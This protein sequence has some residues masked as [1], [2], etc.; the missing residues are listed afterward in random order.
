MRPNLLIEGAN[1]GE[2]L[3]STDTRNVEPVFNFDIR[4]FLYLVRR[5]AGLIATIIGVAL[6]LGTVV[7]MLTTPRFV[8]SAQLQID[9]E[10]DR[11]LENQNAVQP[12]VA[13][14]D[15]DRFLRTQV[16]VIN[17][18]TMSL[19][20]ARALGLIGSKA[21]FDAMGENLPKAEGPI[22]PAR[23]LEE[24][25]LELIRKH[26]TIDLPRESRVVKI[27]FE[28][29]DPELA[30]R[31]ANTYSREYIA[32]NLQRKYD[33]SDYARE[34]LSK[35]L[36]NAKIRLENSERE[37]NEYSRLAGII[38]TG[39][40]VVDEQGRT[41]P[42]ESITNMS[43]IQLNQAALTARADRIA[44][45][46]KW[47]AVSNARTLTIPEV[48]ANPAVQQ[49]LQERASIQ[50]D[51]QQERTRYFDGY[52]AVQ[53]LITQLAEV[54]SQ[55]D[56]I[57]ANIK[58]SMYEQFRAA[59]LRE[60]QLNAQV[61][62]LKGV[63][64]REQQLSVRYG[65]LA[66]EAD[67]NRTL[68]DGLLQRFKEVSAA[69]GISTNN[70]SLVDE[71]TPPLLPS[72]PRLIVNLALALLAGIGIAAVVVVLREQLDDVIRI[73]EEI[74]KKLGISVLG[75]IPLEISDQDLSAILEDPKSR[76]SEAYNTIR[77]ALTYSTTEGTPNSV[78][79]AS[80]QAGE[81]K[82]TTSYA[83][84]RKF[85]DLGKRVLLISAD[86]RR[87]SI[88]TLFQVTNERGLSDL[89]TSRV[90]IES[91]L[92]PTN[93]ENLDFL[94]SGP[95]PP[96]PTE[97]LG[98]TRLREIINQASK[99]YDLVIVDGPPVLGL[100]DAPLLA[101]VV[102]SV[103]FVIESNRGSPGETKSALRRLQTAHGNIIGA[104][105]TKMDRRSV[106]SNYGY[107][108]YE[109]SYEYDDK[110]KSGLLGG[111]RRA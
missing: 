31:I 66:R 22:A 3:S 8:A 91:M 81:G 61:T 20:V 23:A 102:Q 19:R 47:R 16:D 56:A 89:L 32:S 94:S 42:S 6:V 53:Q 108:D 43:L 54:D 5:N 45:E 78:S 111:H 38:R 33:S 18:R 41:R 58:T 97:L 107:Y 14:Q 82:T 98:G 60:S 77:T 101:A 76:L 93:I 30:A 67:T 79:I 109:Y 21:F 110:P 74:E 29:P 59:T 57:T 106:G 9:Q 90:S 55:L 17:S 12:E 80:T 51:L 26:L 84:S 50:A 52:P 87:P 64:T 37:L 44:A 28:S 13:I 7:T 88:H 100:A 104:V 36:A 27:S 73:P 4:S 39:E 11:V 95:V 34:F 83:L 15:A 86:L 35:Q 85:A 105:L 49:L 1:P 63:S 25:T 10:A 71:A 72:S 62:Q 70:V 65:I 103:I 75:S 2:M 68:Y 96:N 40:G 46:G 99:D 24:A 48:L 69:S 92:T